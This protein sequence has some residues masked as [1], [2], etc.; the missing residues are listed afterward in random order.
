[1]SG[2]EAAQAS[3][4][5]SEDRHAPSLRDLEPRQR[6]QIALITIGA[7]AVFAFLRWL[8]T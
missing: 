2:P 5:K 4:L 8:P 7:I 1:M 3:R 6:R